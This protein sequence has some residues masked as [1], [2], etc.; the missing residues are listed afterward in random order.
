MLRFV[1]TVGA[2]LRLAVTS[3]RPPEGR[4]QMAV[5]VSMGAVVRVAHRLFRATRGSWPAGM[6]VGAIATARGIG[7]R[8]AAR[9]RRH[10]ASASNRGDV[11]QAATTDVRVEVTLIAVPAVPR[12][13]PAIEAGGEDRRPAQPATAAGVGGQGKATALGA[14][15]GLPPLGAPLHRPATT[16]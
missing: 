16:G 8:P 14:P 4:E 1:V 2:R 3:V 9:V 5:L 11:R 6:S 7:V 13:H 15:G 10:G 12:C